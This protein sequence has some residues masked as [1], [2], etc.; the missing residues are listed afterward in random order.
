MESTQFEVRVSIGPVHIFATA[1]DRLNI[2]SVPNSSPFVML[3]MERHGDRWELEAESPYYSVGIGKKQTPTPPGLANELL[4][5][6]RNWAE[7]H[8]EEFERA[9]I[10]EYSSII[11]S[12]DEI[13]DELVDELRKTE[14][15]F[16]EIL[17]EP[18]FLRLA[19]AD[20][21][22]KVQDAMRMVHAM[23]LQC[24][25]AAEVICDAACEESG[26]DE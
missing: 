6:G 8:P 26:E 22:E 17:D 4:T 13:L 2:L 12:F 18:E 1:R 5:L 25:A 23:K 15:A 20:L 19:S 11:D 10:S 24:G 3:T 16:R 7:S 9:G 14:K 21:R